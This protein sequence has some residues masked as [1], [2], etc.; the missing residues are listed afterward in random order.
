M[1]ERETH[2][3]GEWPVGLTSNVE[4]VHGSHDLHSRFSRKMEFS[5]FAENFKRLEVLEE[6]FHLAL[7]YLLYYE[8]CLCQSFISGILAKCNTILNI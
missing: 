6:T 1:A 2:T 5:R 8:N 3:D 4:S 7:L